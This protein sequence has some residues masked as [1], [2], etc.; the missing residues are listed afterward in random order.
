DLVN[1]KVTTTQ[2]AH[3]M[4]ITYMSL[5]PNGKILCC[6]SYDGDA[7]FLRMPQGIILKR[8][9]FI[10][11]VQNLLFSKDSK[12]I[13][14]SGSVLS[15]YKLDHNLSATLTSNPIQVYKVKDTNFYT[16]M[17]WIESK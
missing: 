2:E 16:C 7:T 8:F 11:R 15:I 12:Y 13:A 9:K 5:S 17:D 4:D 10:P 3:K 6:A 14:V 1:N